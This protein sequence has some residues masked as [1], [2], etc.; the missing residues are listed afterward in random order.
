MIDKGRADLVYPLG[1]SLLCV[2]FQLVTPRTIP[3]EGYKGLEG[4]FPFFILG[5]TLLLL[6][7]MLNQEA[8]AQDSWSI[9]QYGAAL[10][11]GVSASFLLPAPYSLLAPL[12]AGL[13]LLRYVWPGN[14]RLRFAARQTLALAAS[15]AGAVFVY[16]RL[17]AIQPSTL[18]PSTLLALIS[19]CTALPLRYASPY[20]YLV[21]SGETTRYLLT[22]FDLLPP[23][24]LLYIF[25][26][27]TST[28]V[29][30]GW[31]SV[32]LLVGIMTLTISIRGWL[33]IALLADGKPASIRY[34]DFNILISLCFF[35]ATS[36]LLRTFRLC[37]QRSQPP[38]PS[39]RLP[40]QINQKEFFAIVALGLLAGCL[41]LARPIGHEKK[42]RILIAESNSEWEPAAFPINT[43][44]FGVRSVY[45]YTA[46]TRV[47]QKYFAVEVTK[48]AL[49]PEVLSR[50]DVLILKTPTSQYTAHELRAIWDFVDKG[51]GLWLIGDHTN[52]FGMDAYLNTVSAR[53]GFRFNYDAV[54]EPGYG[55]QLYKA[56]WLISHPC[57]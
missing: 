40:K 12:L 32:L 54:A 41:F 51:G 26:D 46:F 23:A 31:R 21:D 14:L 45:N 16:E 38:S 8:D 15:G 11:G 18:L 10:L 27:L 17:L 50:V 29:K 7:L 34:E 9:W 13:P 57:V 22:W 37:R 24:L 19:Q 25:L 4:W 48:Q 43:D 3:M 6:S 2:A 52:V 36:T 20:L 47:L 5:T 28:W 33:I 56:S 53:Y 49:T 55:R 39:Q 1:A 30:Y 35:V 42:G 44:V